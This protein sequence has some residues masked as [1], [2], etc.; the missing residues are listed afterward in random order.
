MAFVRVLTQKF[1]RDN[2]IIHETS[3]IY[4]PQQNGRVECKHRAEV[5]R[6]LHF[7]ASLLIEFWSKYSLIVVYFI[8]RAPIV[9]LH[10]KSSH[11]ILFHAKS[12]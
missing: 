8:D 1:Y 7:Q 9:K 4:T 5:A 2:G 12:S 11:E 10:G 3:C 6:A